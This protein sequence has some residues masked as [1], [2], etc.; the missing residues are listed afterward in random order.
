MQGSIR[1][2]PKGPFS[3]LFNV[4]PSLLLVVVRLLVLPLCLS[5]GPFLI[6]IR[7]AGLSLPLH[8]ILILVL[9]LVLVLLLA[10]LLVLS[11][12]TALRLHRNSI[13]SVDVDDVGYVA[14]ATSVLLVYEVWAEGGDADEEE[15]LKQESHASH[16]QSGKD[17][18][19]KTAAVH[20]PVDFNAGLVLVWMSVFRV[21]VACVWPVAHL[22]VQC[23]VVLSPVRGGGV[24]VSGVWECGDVCR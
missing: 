6:L 15:K 23:V 20:L 1:D 4:Y 19:T 11:L 17:I 10:L 14:N 22:V 9:H 18:K 3:S 16:R 5:Y 8:T 7:V 2:F 12:V 24:V 13:R 21:A